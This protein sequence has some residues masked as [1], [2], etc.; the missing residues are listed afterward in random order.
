MHVIGGNRHPG[1]MASRRAVDRAAQRVSRPRS[2]EDHVTMI[3]ALQRRQSSSPALLALEDL[4]A[5]PF[6][7]D[8]QLK[9]SLLPSAQKSTLLD[10]R[11]AGTSAIRQAPGGANA[12]RFRALAYGVLRTPNRSSADVCRG[13]TRSA[14]FLRLL[15]RLAGSV[16][17]IN[18][19][20]SRA[21][22]SGRWT[23]HS[24]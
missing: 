2:R 21:I 3:R 15:S 1:R 18:S 22:S 7:C 23:R 11:L 16:V 24:P 4:Q 10:R 14:T 12:T 19:V 20:R 5:S 6:R 8:Q 13:A 17:S 9:T